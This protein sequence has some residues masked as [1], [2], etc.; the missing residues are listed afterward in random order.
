MSSEEVDI[1][2]VDDS[3]DDVDL[4]L[5]ALRSENLANHVFIAR[6][7]EEALDFIFC[8]GPHAH[9]SFDHPPKLVL[10]DLKMP[11]VDG[12]QVLKQIK[13]DARTK[14]IPV[15]LMTSSREERD[16][17][18]GYNLGVNSYLQKPVDFGNFRE[19]VKLLGLYW[20]VTNQPP[21]ANG[22]TQTAKQGQ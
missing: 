5:H 21:V 7:G 15:V 3:Q 18:S 6:D 9:R 13:D 22:K 4:T 19:M 16:M 10:L 8:S 17:V 20:L 1:L 14:T 2:L 12:L 11:K